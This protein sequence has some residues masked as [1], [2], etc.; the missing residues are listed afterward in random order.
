MTAGRFDDPRLPQLLADVRAKFHAD[1]GG[2]QIEELSA[3]NGPTL[4]RFSG[5]MDGYQAGSSMMFR[6]EAQHL[7]VGRQWEPILP[8]NLLAQLL[9]FQPVGEVNINVSKVEFDGVHWKTDA[10][11]EC[12]SMQF[13]YDKFPYRLGTRHRH[14]A[15]G[16]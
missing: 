11:V 5:R 8:P 6:G 4:L 13:T 10:T 7:L 14:V 12:L 2:I 1:N 16:V 9:K 3:H 15:V